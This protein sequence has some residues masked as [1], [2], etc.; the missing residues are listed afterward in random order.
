MRIV[1]NE[2]FINVRWSRGA[3]GCVPGVWGGEVP[4]VAIFVFSPQLPSRE[5]ATLE[6]LLCVTDERKNY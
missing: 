3:C 2:I 4:G 5:G 6:A 1:R